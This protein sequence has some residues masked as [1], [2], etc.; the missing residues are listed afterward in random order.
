MLQFKDRPILT[1]ADLL[2][3]AGLFDGEGTGGVYKHKKVVKGKAYFTSV[4]HLAI[5]MTDPD[6]VKF[7]SLCF[8]GQYYHHMDSP[9]RKGLKP[10]SRWQCS[11]KQAREVAAVLLP[12]VKNLAKVQQL[13]A[14]VG[15]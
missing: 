1:E 7:V 5:Q 2:Y 15:V 4:A 11:S 10:L 12:Y 9:S 6:P 8:P 14:V 13:S 3:I